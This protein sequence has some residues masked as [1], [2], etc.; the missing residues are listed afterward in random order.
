MMRLFIGLDFIVSDIARPVPV[1]LRKLLSLSLLLMG[2]KVICMEILPLFFF[3]N[4]KGVC[5]LSSLSVND[6][7]REEQPGGGGD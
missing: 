2:R 6:G 4:A 1:S 3:C 7:Q 5:R